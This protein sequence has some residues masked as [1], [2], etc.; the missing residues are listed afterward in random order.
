MAISASVIYGDC[1]GAPP[2]RPAFLLLHSPLSFFLLRSACMWARRR[3]SLPAA[4]CLHDELTT[5]IDPPGLLPASFADPD[6]Y[7]LIYAA[8]E[9]HRAALAEH[10]VFMRG[11]R[12]R[13][14]ASGFTGGLMSARE[15]AANERAANIARMAALRPQRQFSLGDGRGG[16]DMVPT[17]GR[18]PDRAEFRSPGLQRQVQ[19]LE[20]W[21]PS[22][23]VA[24][25]CVG[26]VQP[27]ILAC[28]RGTKKSAAD[29]WT[30]R[31]ATAE[32]GLSPETAHEAGFVAV[33]S[34][35]D[36]RLPL[37]VT[38]RAIAAAA[39]EA[40]AA[41][42]G[43]AGGAAGGAPGGE[44]A[45]DAIRQRMQRDTMSRGAC[46]L[47]FCRSSRPAS[48]LQPNPS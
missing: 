29:G 39:E 8:V 3:C 22:E 38:Q 17:I 25:A 31:R 44:A 21:F 11:L 27:H 36:E 43:G 24:A 5:A 2:P 45:V 30:F 46:L 40:Q 18:P 37:T 32:E 6:F 10:A 34:A 4:R 47:L 33:T 48:R 15:E 41:A 23:S 19:G 13:R 28:L 42:G 20:Y 7:S 14:K 12:E 1:T 16:E 35:D 26:S 9:L